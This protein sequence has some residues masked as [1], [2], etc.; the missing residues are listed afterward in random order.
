MHLLGVVGHHVQHT[1]THTEMTPKTSTVRLH[2]PVS[3][4]L[5]YRACLPVE[6]MV[7]RCIAHVV[8]A[9]G[10][11]GPSAG[12][13]VTQ[14]LVLS[15]WDRLSPPW[16]SIIAARVQEATDVS[17]SHGNPPNVAV[18]HPSD[19]V[20]Q[21]VPVCCI[22]SSPVCGPLAAARERRPAA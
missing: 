11:E 12:P 3:C 19:A 9:E 8:A 6:L 4:M 21:V 16:V 17:T 1:T 2:A 5:Q 15:C 13:S 10:I 18:Q 7:P 22:V 14:L 20:I